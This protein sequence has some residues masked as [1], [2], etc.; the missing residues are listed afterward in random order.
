MTTI[1]AP[2]PARGQ[3]RVAMP[4]CSHKPKPY[5]G[6]SRAE[7]IAM[8]KQ[9]TTP[10]VFTLYKDP[11]LIVE[12]HMQWLFD[13]TGRRYLDFLAGIV[14]V[15]CGHCHPKITAR[16]HE[17]A[18]TLQHATTIYLHPN[19]VLLAKKL[20]SKMPKGL[21]VTYFVNSG[22]AASVHTDHRAAAG[23][24]GGRGF[25]RECYAGFVVADDGGID[26]RGNGRGEKRV[27]RP[28][29]SGEGEWGVG[30]TEQG[31]ASLSGEMG[32]RRP[33]N[34]DRR[35]GETSQWCLATLVSSPTPR[36]SSPPHP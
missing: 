13:E 15:G 7:L 23:A 32:D 29:G 11:L 1:P 21:D 17:Q 14:T 9:F 10:A 8:R 6:P 27:A 24:D 19:L 20:A 18:D 22:T 25:A 16:I 5:T 2:A 12:G 30:R 33:A 4:A 26:S 31:G 36:C 28:A 3:T 34:P 35:S